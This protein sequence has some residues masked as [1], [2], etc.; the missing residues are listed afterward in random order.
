[1]SVEDDLGNTAPAASGPCTLRGLCA[2]S[3]RD[4]NMFGNHPARVRA[5]GVLPVC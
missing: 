2:G 5:S 4:V 3:H 1:M